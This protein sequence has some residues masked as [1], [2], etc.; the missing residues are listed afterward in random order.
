MLH[1]V[2]LAAR[3]LVRK[4]GFAA[5]AVVTLALGSHARSRRSWPASAVGDPVTLARWRRW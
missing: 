2:R 1:D 3:M 5:A 4:R